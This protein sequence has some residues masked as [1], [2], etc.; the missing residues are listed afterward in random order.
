MTLWLERE[1]SEAAVVQLERYFIGETIGVRNLRHF[2]I[3]L[4]SS[5]IPVRGRALKSLDLEGAV[6][7]FLRE[8]RCL[9]LR[10]W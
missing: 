5:S 8:A 2:G 1:F 7:L 3:I 10:G 9:R 4:S 6:M